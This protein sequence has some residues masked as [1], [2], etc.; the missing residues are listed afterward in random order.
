MASR[1]T[2]N[3]TKK[4]DAHPCFFDL[5]E[6]IA[7]LAFL[8]GHYTNISI[9]KPVIY[10]ERVWEDIKKKE[11]TAMKNYNTLQPDKLKYKVEEEKRT[12]KG[13]AALYL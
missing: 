8:E 7:P 13:F 2:T 9:L 11:L 6:R 10:V 4:P 5:E 12:E 3:S 1:N